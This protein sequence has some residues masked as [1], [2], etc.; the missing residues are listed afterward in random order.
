MK[1]SILGLL[2]SAL[3]T[4]STICHAGSFIDLIFRF[5]PPVIPQIS[6]P[7]VQPTTKGTCATWCEDLG[8][9]FPFCYYD[10]QDRNCDKFR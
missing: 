8:T 4:T 7:V 10:P 9:G 3:L 1:Y 6:V 2:I 5:K